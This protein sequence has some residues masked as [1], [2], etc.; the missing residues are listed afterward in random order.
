MYSALLAWAA[1]GAAASLATAWGRRDDPMAR[2]E[3][4]F[5]PFAS[6]LPAT[7]EVG[8]LEK[9]GGTDDDV[10]AYYAAQYALVP[11]VVLSR[12]GPEFLIVPR[13]AEQ[14]GGDERLQGFV[15]VRTF[16][17]GHRLFRRLP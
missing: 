11:R 14:P 4:E 10:R 8:Y 5:L 15:P 3:A 6:L 7:G 9:R 12:T 16:A 2:L 13:D 1:S 17:T